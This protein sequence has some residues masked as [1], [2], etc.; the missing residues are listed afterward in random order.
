MMT[1]PLIKLSVKKGPALVR[2]RRRPRE[3]Q[4]WWA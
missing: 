1:M 3:D 2:R 4:F